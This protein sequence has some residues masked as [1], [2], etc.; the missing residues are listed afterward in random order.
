M[1]TK[2]LLTLSLSILFWT[3]PVTF[4]QN[5]TEEPIVVRS[6]NTRGVSL[7]VPYHI[8]GDLERVIVVDELADCV[9]VSTRTTEGEVLAPNR[10]SFSNAG[11]QV[12]FLFNCQEEKPQPLFAHYQVKREISPAM[13]LPGQEIEVKLIV[14]NDGKATG[15]YSLSEILSANA[16]LVIN[17]EAQANLSW[18]ADLAAGQTNVHRYLAQA[19]CDLASSNLQA[20]FEPKRPGPGVSGEIISGQIELAQL[21]IAMESLSIP[22]KANRPFEVIFSLTNTSEAKLQLD[23]NL[24][25]ETVE[26]IK[27]PNSINIPPKGLIK[28]PA[29]LISRLV[30]VNTFEVVPV[31]EE[32]GE[33]NSYSFEINVEPEPTLPPVAVSTTLSF[34]AFIDNLA[35]TPEGMVFLV[36]LPA[37]VNYVLGSAKLDG[38]TV[39]D[40]LQTDDVL[41]FELGH[42]SGQIS[43]AVNH[44][45]TV[46]ITEE[47]TALIAL[48]PEPVQVSGFAEAIDF[49]STADIIAAPKVT[50]DRV[51][52]IITSPEAGLVIRSGNVVGITTDTPSKDNVTLF[53]NNQPISD[54]Q[55]GQETLDRNLG[56][57]TLNY[58]A[59]PLEVGPNNIRLESIGA[60]GELLT[61][62]TTIFVSGR[63][64]SVK[65]TALSELVADSS[66]PLSFALKVKDAWGNTPSDGF[67]TIELENADFGADD[68]STQQLGYQVRYV[69]GKAILKVAPL[70]VPDE[71]SIIASL[72]NDADSLRFKQEFVVG[73]NF[74]PWL[75]TGIG[76]V[77]VTYDLEG[78]GDFSDDFQVGYEASFFA[79]G[80]LLDNYQ[81]TVAANYPEDRLG[82]YGNPYE[83]FAVTGSSGELSQDATSRDGVFVRIENNLSYL[84]YGDFDTLFED[85][86]FTLNRSYTGLSGIYRLGYA[87]AFIRGYLVNSIT[88]LERQEEIPSDG[89]SFY[90]LAVKPIAEGSIRI[91]V[92]K[93]SSFDNSLIDDEVDDGNDPLLG[94]LVELSHYRINEELGFISLTRPLPRSDTRGNSYFLKVSYRVIDEEDGERDWRFGAQ[95]GYDAYLGNSIDFI[96][97]RASMYHEVFEDRGNINVASAGASLNTKNLEASVELAYGGNEEN[98]G[99]ATVADIDYSSKNFQVSSYYRYNS[100]D[101]RS[102][103]IKDSQ[104]GHSLD[105]HA[106]LVITK[107]IGFLTDAKFSYRADKLTYDID[108]L[109]NYQRNDLGF[110]KNAGVEFGLEVTNSATRLLAGLAVNDLFGAQ[111]TRIRVLHRQSLNEE[112][113][114]TTDFT[115]GYGVLGILELTI[116]DRL[117]WGVSNS[118]LVGLNTL[119]DSS[120]FGIFAVEAT[121]EFTEK[122]DTNFGLGTTFSNASLLGAA[123][124]WG[125]TQIKA[126]YSLPTGTSGLAGHI[127]TGIS[128]S[129]PVTKEISL[130]AS[131]EQDLDLEES[132]NNLHVLGAGVRYDAEDTNISFRYELRLA[133]DVKH[134]VTAGFNTFLGNNLFMSSKLDLISD[135]GADPQEGLRFNVS[136]AYRGDAIDILTQHTLELGA[137]HKD[138][139]DEIHG[140]FRVVVPVSDF[141]ISLGY[142]YRYRETTGLQDMLSL[143]GSFQA[144]EGGNISV[145]GSLYH[146]W[147]EDEFAYG[148]TAEVS[149][150]VVCGT[151]AVAGYS[152]NTLSDPVFG[153]QGLQLRVDIAVDEQFNCNSPKEISGLIFS[154]DNG[155]GIKD[156]NEK[157]VNRV[158]VRLYDNGNYLVSDAHSK[159]DGSYRLRD[160]RRGVYTLVV[161]LP[162]GYEGFSPMNQGENDQHD[163]DVNA[164]GKSD[165]LDLKGN[166]SLDVGL[167]PLGLVPQQ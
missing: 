81:L 94:E 138:N 101:F 162:E 57:K 114:S 1:K 113:N 38:S 64:D 116:T 151:Y 71:I 28:V 27:K 154:D 23:L 46:L 145:F 44:S 21:E 127:N 75:V 93:R 157:G 156:K 32:V 39:T 91:E 135:E 53:V 137:Y 122:G 115:V 84:Q 143:G 108:S 152:W 50:R 88:S 45:G 20:V 13:A 24:R 54:K 130:E 6:V 3:S 139:E 147:Q 164:K 30:G 150:R 159:H 134:V 79:R 47:N 69:D 26:L 87:P 144:W 17:S 140:D 66:T 126:N 103:D 8:E 86:E 74:R 131:F 163:S 65:M 63:P 98:S 85:S 80:T 15:N 123:A 119:Q 120:L 41:V 14:E 129:L 78:S 161:T 31:Y 76:S 167:L 43:F 10:V 149:Q 148:L 70:P 112:E 55:I 90:S 58:I 99:I 118:L 160:L 89:T 97:L 51:G 73:S 155:N 166:I 2:S 153:D 132:D 111:N 52:A 67:L 5:H 7:E 25:S 146:D 136:A 36:R 133:E 124:N 92:I 9:L 59:V 83:S 142:V 37:E 77:G 102:A 82:I 104:E 19:S 22:V 62:E 72:G 4:T 105:A 18:Q 107:N 109:V 95:I 12:I 48:T 42:T 100:E 35:S 40:P 56:R 117:D 68:E 34:D 33:C 29:T 128:T 110:A 11:G 125:S 16:G 96:A 60:S 121:G 141:D 61:D 158:L 49:Y 165:H 106:A